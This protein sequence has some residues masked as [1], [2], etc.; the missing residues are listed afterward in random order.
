MVAKSASGR[1]SHFGKTDLIF[2][3]GTIGS[4]DY[5]KILER[6]KPQI[7]KFMGCRRWVF[8][9]DSAPA[10]SA[11]VTQDWLKE[12]VPNF[13]SKKE[14]PAKSPDLNPIENLWSYLKNEAQKSQPKNKDQL[15]KTLQKIWRAIPLEQIRKFT[16]SMKSRLE[17][18]IEQEGGHTGY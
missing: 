17:A 3:E 18:C 4:D 2:F 8:V 1:I 6:A 13:I 16:D 11:A 5:I 12:N 9:Q 14:W 10:H 7:Q 15:K